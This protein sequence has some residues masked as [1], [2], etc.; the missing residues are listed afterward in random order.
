MEFDPEEGSDPQAIAALEGVFGLYFAE[1]DTE[2]VFS[3]NDPHISL[4]LDIYQMFLG[5]LASLVASVR[6]CLHILIASALRVAEFKPCHG[7]C[8]IPCPLQ[9]DWA[10]ATVVRINFDDFFA[11][12]TLADLRSALK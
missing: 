3:A 11:R 9:V 1:D 7:C 6:V 2:A 12:S 5:P 8:A 10:R 4:A